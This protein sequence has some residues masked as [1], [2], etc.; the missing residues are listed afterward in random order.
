VIARALVLASALAALAAPAESPP[1]APDAYRN[2]LEALAAS[3]RT[4]REDVRA[5]AEAARRASDGDTSFLEP[6]LQGPLSAADRESIARCAEV[7]LARVTRI[8]DAGV[9]RRAGALRL[10]E[11]RSLPAPMP[12]GESASAAA[13]AEDRSLL[14]RIGEWIVQALRALLEWLRRFFVGS[15]DAG[16]RGFTASIAAFWIAVAA[17][18]ALGVATAFI[19]LRRWR[20]AAPA[21]PAAEAAE[22]PPEGPLAAAMARAPDEWLDRFAAHAREG[23]F[24][25]AIRDLLLGCL[26]SLYRH[27][28]LAYR[29]GSTNRDYVAALPE[30]SGEREALARI[31]AVFD[32]HW[33]GLIPA[34]R[35]DARAAAAC[36][37]RIFGSRA[38][39]ESE[40]GMP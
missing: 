25:D 40:R 32:R 8:P 23:L 10:Q 5:E 22:A 39:I 12:A 17:A 35:D 26:V 34:D 6:C 14:A 4:G 38:A 21:A 30:G 31:A 28:A 3:L 18:V 27:G 1:A 7:I 2:A 20:A 11:E 37:Q 16:G 33:Y 36:A 29:R 24:R 19:L 13:G 15:S 9:G